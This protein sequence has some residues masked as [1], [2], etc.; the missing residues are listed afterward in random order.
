MDRKLLTEYCAPVQGL[1]AV[2]T[3]LAMTTRVLGGTEYYGLWNLQEVRRTEAQYIL[4]PAT[5]S[6]MDG[7]TAAIA[8]LGITRSMI[9]LRMNFSLPSQRIW[10][11]V[12]KLQALHISELVCFL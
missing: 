10:N 8:T 3:C 5:S 1:E 7:S 6:L 9:V 2:M 12:G 4:V 11:R